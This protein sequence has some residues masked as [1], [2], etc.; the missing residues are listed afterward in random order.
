MSR[1]PAFLGPYFAGVGHG[2]ETVPVADIV[3][4]TE[5]VSETSAVMAIAR[6]VEPGTS[7]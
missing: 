5:R 3:I 1:D 6:L 7:A 4:D 2:L